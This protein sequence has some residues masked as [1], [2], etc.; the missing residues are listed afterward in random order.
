[1]TDMRQGSGLQIIFAI[2]LGLMVTAFIGVGVYTFYPSREPELDRQIR[3]LNRREQALKNAVAPEASRPTDRAQIQQI[4]DERNDLLDAAR[5]VREVWGRNTSIILIIFATLTMAI[6]LVRADQLPVISNGLLLGG[7]F[8]MVYGV[9]WIIATNTSIVRFIVMTAALVITLGLGYARFV[10]GRS[11][12][13]LPSG[14]A[15]ASGQGL[16]GLERRVQDLE[17]RMDEAANALGHSP[18]GHG[19]DRS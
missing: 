4:A 14:D 1:M 6:S 13:V 19:G 3:E 9:G 11:V 15:M 8:T 18:L 16:A 12:A 17:R 5:A 2:F 7:V 10:R